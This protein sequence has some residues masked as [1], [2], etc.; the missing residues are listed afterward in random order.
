VDQRLVRQFLQR[1]RVHRGEPVV[2]RG[3]DDD[4]L[5]SEDLDVLGGHGGRRGDRNVRSAG[6]QY[7]E[8]PVRAGELLQVKLDLGEAPVPAAQHRGE[9]PAGHRLGARDPDPAARARRRAPGRRHHLARRREGDPRLGHRHQPGRGRPDP[10]RQPLD[11]RRAELALDRGDLVRKGRLGHVQ[12]RRGL[13]QRA[14]L[15]DRDEALEPSHRQH[16]YPPARQRR[17]F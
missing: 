7:L 12:Q 6:P 3:D 8:H 14:L 9:Q 1:D 4:L 2:R 11:D 13:G 5:G 10:P 16:R 15:D 17:L